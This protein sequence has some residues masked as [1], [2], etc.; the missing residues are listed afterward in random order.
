MPS[1]PFKGN[2]I[3]FY[4]NWSAASSIAMSR[5]WKYHAFTSL[6]LRTLELLRIIILLLSILCISWITYISRS[7]AFRDAWEM[8][9]Y[10]RAII[11][12]GA[13]LSTLVK[14][15]FSFRISCHFL[16]LAPSNGKSVTIIR[17]VGETQS[18]SHFRFFPQPP[19]P[20]PVIHNYLRQT[21][22]KLLTLLLD[23]IG[24]I[25]H[26]EAKVFPCHP[27]DTHRTSTSSIVWNNKWTHLMPHAYFSLSNCFIKW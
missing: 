1:Q 27:F 15:K 13:E 24:I 9:T 18:R 5:L 21:R 16:L 22:S 7:H 12:R 19:T 14:G 26:H 25:F 23:I 11:E 3:C 8:N 17:I 20:S 10:M 6:T 4:S 2:R